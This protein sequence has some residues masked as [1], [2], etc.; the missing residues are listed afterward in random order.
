[1]SQDLTLVDFNVSSG[2]SS[3]DDQYVL[4]TTAKNGTFSIR[5]ELRADLIEP[6]V[7]A[8]S[9][10]TVSMSPDGTLRIYADCMSVDAAIGAESNL[11]DLIKQSISPLVLEDEPDVEAKLQKLKK[12]LVTSLATVDE[13][14]SNL[15][16][17]QRPEL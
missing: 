14:I 2:Y 3:V 4:S 17:D 15:E 10:A 6:T 16:Q 7:L 8:K 13:A 12:R 9:N 1:M 5:L 11:E